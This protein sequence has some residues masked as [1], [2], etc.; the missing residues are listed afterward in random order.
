MKTTILTFALVMCLGVAVYSYPG[1]YELT[2]QQHADDQLEKALA[3]F[4]LTNLQ[5]VSAHMHMHMSV[6]MHV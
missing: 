1:R 5:S 3:Q 2:R 4:L 6:Y